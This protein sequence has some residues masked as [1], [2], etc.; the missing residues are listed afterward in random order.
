MLATTTTIVIGA[1]AGIDVGMPLGKDLAKQ[2]RQVVDIRYDGGIRHIGAGDLKVFEEFRRKFPEEIVDYQHAGWL[3]RDGLLT[4]DSIDDFL[5]RHM[6]NSKVVSFGK[7]AI[8]RCILNGEKRSPLYWDRGTSQHFDLKRTEDNWH[9]RLFRMIARGVKPS[10]LE[11]L[12]S[13]VT[14]VN[15]NYDRCLEQFLIHALQPAFGIP[16]QEAVEIAGRATILRPYGSVGAIISRGQQQIIP[17]GGNEIAAG[18]IE[19]SKNIKTYTEQVDLGDNLSAIKDAVKSAMTVIFLGFGF[20]EQNLN[21]IS[22][23]GGASARRIFGTT[24]GE[25]GENRTLIE[26]RMRALLDVNARNNCGIFLP[27][28]S[29]GKLLED[30]SRSISGNESP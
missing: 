17:F 24:L 6:E 27:P 5:E 21:L 8:V 2:I 28:S 26:R 25:S 30:F 12:F 16:E 15:F 9:L 11:Q 4:T 13:N 19:I 18:C 10:K 14:F 29:C 22:S 23:P 7:A 1:G 20:H 3:L